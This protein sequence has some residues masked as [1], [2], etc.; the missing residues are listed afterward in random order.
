MHDVPHSDATKLRISLA[1]KGKPSNRRG[2]TLS[3]DTRD[4]I[5]RSKKGVKV[6]SREQR[7]KWRLTRA[8]AGNPAWINGRSKNNAYYR[9]IREQR[10]REAP[11]YHSEG[12]WQTLKVQYGNQCAS[13]KRP[14]P[15]VKLT[16]DHI[17]PL[18]RGGS[19]FIENIQPLC[20]SCNSRKRTKI[21]TY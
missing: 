12:E 20:Q 19:H 18:A 3:R 13:C 8:G 17:I 14:E 6:H 5:S 10:E 9:R 2:V 7:A 16:K 4:R 21:I 11:G 1:K 15:S